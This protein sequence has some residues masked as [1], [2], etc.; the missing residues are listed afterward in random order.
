MK[1]HDEDRI[2][3][4][5]GRWEIDVFASVE[6]SLRQTAMTDA[7][8]ANQHAEGTRLHAALG[9][10]LTGLGEYRVKWGRY[11]SVVLRPQRSKTEDA[12]FWQQQ[13]GRA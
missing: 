5:T 12:A 8:E 13:Q 7:W 10:Y 9:D 6:V 3:I 1:G 2:V 4:S 11:Q